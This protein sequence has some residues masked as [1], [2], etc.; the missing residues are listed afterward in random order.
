MFFTKL[1]Q[2][3]RWLACELPEVVQGCADSHLMIL[4]QLTLHSKAQHHMSQAMTWQN[5]FM[6]QTWQYMLVGYVHICSSNTADALRPHVHLQAR[7]NASSLSS[8]ASG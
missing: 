3:L 5:L 8:N 7:P 6:F 4:A 2:R 1:G